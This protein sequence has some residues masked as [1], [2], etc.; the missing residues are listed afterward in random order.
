MF[1]KKILCLKLQFEK[2]TKVSKHCLDKPKKAIG[3]KTYFL[4]IYFKS[5]YFICSK[6]SKIFTVIIKFIYITSKDTIIYLGS[7]KF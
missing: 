3:L 6:L 2:S 5:T 7:I 4:F 1:K